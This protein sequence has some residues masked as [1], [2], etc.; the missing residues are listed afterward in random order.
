MFLYYTCEFCRNVLLNAIQIPSRSRLN[1]SL[2]HKSKISACAI[3]IYTVLFVFDEHRREAKRARL[4]YFNDI[5]SK[6]VQQPISQPCKDHGIVRAE[7][8]SRAKMGEAAVYFGADVTSQAQMC[9]TPLKLSEA[10][11][12]QSF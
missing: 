9:P 4:L 5:S 1:H 8:H 6:A 12:S 3:G 10:L 7:P 2:A 11:S